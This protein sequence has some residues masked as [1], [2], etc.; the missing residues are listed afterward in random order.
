MT[1]NQFVNA[2]KRAVDELP[3]P[4]HPFLKNL[5]VDVVDWPS[6]ADLE[7]F[8]DEKALLG[9]FEGSSLLDEGIVTQPKRIRLFR[10][11]LEAASRNKE[12]LVCH[13]QETVVHEIAHHFGMSEEDLEPFEQAMEERRRKLF[14][15]E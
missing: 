15:E 12:D 5:V 7:R 11:N 10:R 14:G 6:Y 8:G 2:A 4:F 13:I 3:A 9:M 1:V